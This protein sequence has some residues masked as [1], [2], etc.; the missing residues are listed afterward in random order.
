M[1]RSWRLVLGKWKR[2]CGSIQ[3]KQTVYFR[4][5]RKR[6]AATIS[7]VE[8]QREDAMRVDFSVA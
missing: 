7:V 6:L 3:R 4:K 5:G 1:Q 8:R 2:T